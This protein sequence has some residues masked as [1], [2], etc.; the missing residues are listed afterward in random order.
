M[1][2]NLPIEEVIAEDKSLDLTE[3]SSQ[4]LI[5][6]PT[7]KEQS[8][9]GVE[10]L[11]YPDIDSPSEERTLPTAQTGECSESHLTGDAMSIN[12]HSPTVF[13]GKCIPCA[14]FLTVASREKVEKLAST[15][16]KDNVYFARYENHTTGKIAGLIGLK[17]LTCLQNDTWLNCEIVNWHACA[18]AQLLG[19]DRESTRLLGSGIAQVILAERPNL[20]DILFSHLSTEERRQRNPR[21]VTSFATVI[22][23]VCFN[24]HWVVVCIEPW[25]KCISVFDSM[26]GINGPSSTCQFIGERFQDYVNHQSLFLDEPARAVRDFEVYQV[27]NLPL[28]KNTNDC[29]VYASE[30][31]AKLLGCTLPEECITP[32]GAATYRAKMLLALMETCSLDYNPI[33]Q[34]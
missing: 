33:N 17:E 24:D 7:K 25:R 2:V 22:V 32:R 27:D 13:S 8:G 26:R 20:E 21:S 29:G 10:A 23:P 1:P 5:E 14:L 18:V 28:Q 11:I 6:M 31:I 3:P 9:A 16:K 4:P 19:V 15:R 34:E 30:R 12:Q